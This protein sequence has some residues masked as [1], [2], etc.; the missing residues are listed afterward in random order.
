[1]D[2]PLNLKLVNFLDSIGNADPLL[3]A[4]IFSVMATDSTPPTSTVSVHLIAGA[5]LVMVGATLMPIAVA[6]L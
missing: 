6:T 4:I 3:Q 1:M 5:H 2:I